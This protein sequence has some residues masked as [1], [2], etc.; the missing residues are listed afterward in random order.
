VYTGTL[1]AVSVYETWS[2]NVEVWSV[3]DDT[4]MDL[5]GVTEI[6]LK[7]RDEA[8]RFVE[9]TLTMSGGDITIPSTGIVQWRA[10]QTAMGSLEPK[11]YEV[12]LTLADDT[13]TVTLILGHVSVVE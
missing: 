5:T 10:E 11:T 9:M 2:E 8:L 1:P 12:I 13:D 3:D 6:T 7:L 4:L